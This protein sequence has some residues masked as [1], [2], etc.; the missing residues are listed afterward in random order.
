[1]LK[2][3]R[4]TIEIRPDIVMRPNNR[5]VKRKRRLFPVFTAPPPTTIVIIM[6]TKPEGVTFT[7][8]LL[9]LKRDSNLLKKVDKIFFPFFSVNV[10]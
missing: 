10:T 7:R 4:F 2:K 3:D 8:Y 9:Y 1:M 6:K 5:L